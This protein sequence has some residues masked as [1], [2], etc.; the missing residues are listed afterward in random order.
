LWVVVGAAL[1]LTPWIWR[2]DGWL[3]AKAEELEESEHGMA[4]W[5]LAAME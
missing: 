4:S 2:G 1:L 3:R 5:M